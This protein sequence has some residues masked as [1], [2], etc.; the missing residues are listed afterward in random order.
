MGKITE[1]ENALMAYHHKKPNWIPV[2]YDAIQY[3]GFVSGN[4]CGQGE[5]NLDVFGAK[6]NADGLPTP[7]P[8]VP[9]LINDIKEWKEKLVF[10]RPKEWDWEAIAKFERSLCPEDKVM[11][12]FSEQGIFDRLTTVLGFENALC[13]L[14]TDPEECAAF[15]ERVADYKIELIECVA[16]YVKPDVFMYPDDVATGTGLFMRPE[17]YRKVIKPAHARII[18]A[19]R[20]TD[21]I[22]EQH[23]CGKCD[24]IIPDNVEMGVECFFPA[25]ACNDIPGILEKYGD[26]L[27]VCG[28]FDSM[29]PAA[30]PDATAEQMKEEAHRIIDSYGKY[31][32]FCV[33]PVIMDNPNWAIYHPSPNQ[34]AFYEEFV[35][36]RKKYDN[37]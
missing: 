36:Y 34:K 35:E 9:T 4:E 23:T 26:R 37:A 13:A 14:F 27:T 17:V 18:E 24:D 15:A 29:A 11:V 3:I 19:I 33:V 28:G 12:W 8:T 21:M 32:S 7:D 30:R 6:W 10:P 1:R 20:K 22:A 31:G 5:G 16:K 2:M 25:Q